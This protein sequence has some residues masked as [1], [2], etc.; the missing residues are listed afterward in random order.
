MNRRQANNP[1]EKQAHLPV[2]QAIVHNSVSAY[3]NL[4]GLALSLYQQGLVTA[5][6]V[7]LSPLRVAVWAAQQSA[8]SPTPMPQAAESAASHK[9]TDAAEEAVRSAAQVAGQNRAEVAQEDDAEVAVPVAQNEAREAAVPQNSE[10]VPRGAEAA[11]PTAQQQEDVESTGREVQPDNVTADES[12]RSDAEMT[13][14][15]DEQVDPPVHSLAVPEPSQIPEKSPT[16]EEPPSDTREE[17]VMAEPSPASTEETEPPA[18]EA[19][20][21]LEKLPPPPEVTEVELPPPPQV[22]PSIIDELPPP[23]QVSPS[24]IDELPPPPQVSPSI[25]DELPPPPVP[26]NQNVVGVEP[27]AEPAVEEK[28][29]RTKGLGTRRATATEAAYRKAEELGV[30]LLEI[31]GSGPNGRIT[32]EDVRGKSE[33]AGS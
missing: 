8:Q 10:I 30:D 3:A 13:D 32:V 24:I 29:P 9:G 17:P 28:A 4:L 27:S 12:A 11:D 19:T 23:P 5:G 25:I 21:I 20:S 6:Q 31:E 1:Q 22:P 15:A 14:G 2:V 26:G 18:Y 7:A 16:I 33:Q